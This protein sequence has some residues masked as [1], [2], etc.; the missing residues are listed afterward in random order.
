MALYV[1]GIVLWMLLTPV[2]PRAVQSGLGSLRVTLASYWPALAMGIG[3]AIIT[4]LVVIFGLGMKPVHPWGMLGFLFLMSATWLALIQ[5][6]NAVFGQAVGRIVTL[7]ALMI[8]LVSSGGIYPVPT[9]ALPTQ[10]FHPFDPMTYS[11]NGLRQLTVGDLGWRLP[12]AVIVL[13]GIMIVSLV[14]TTVFA[15]RNRRYTMGRLFR[16]IQ[17]KSIQ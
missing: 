13:A 8:M 7:M 16:P 15:H 14:I 17:A 5:M 6:F 4:Y 9:N 11:V 2:Q 3:Q 1:G 12:Q 10:W